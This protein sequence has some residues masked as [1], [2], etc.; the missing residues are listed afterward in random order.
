MSLDNLEKKIYQYKNSKD[1]KRIDEGE[2]PPSAFSVKEDWDEEDENEENAHEEKRSSPLRYFSWLLWITIPVLIIWGS[3][4]VFSKYFA[5]SKDILLEITAPEKVER[6]TPFDVKVTITNQTPDLL[7]QTNL[8]I[9]L[10]SGLV[11]LS[12]FEKNA[13]VNESLGDIGDGSFAQKT[14]KFLA[15]GDVN[16][17]QRITAS[18]SYAILKTRFEE[19][20]SQEILIDYPGLKIDIKKPDVLMNKSAFDIEIDYENTSA[21]DFSQLT[22]QASYPSEFEFISSDLPPTSL[23]NTWN[24]GELK[25]GS[26]GTFL[27]K[28]SL[29]IREQK[30]ISI[31]FIMSVNFFGKNYPLIDT[32]VSFA[33]APSP[34]HIETSI[35]N[36]NEYIARLG[37][38]LRYIIRYENQ[39][40][41]ALQ[42]AVVKAQLVGDLFDIETIDTNG[43]IDSIRKSITWNKSN[44][45]RLGIV[46]PG[47]SDQVGFSIKLKKQFPIERLS[48][49]NFTVRVDVEITSPSVPY[50]LNSKE[51]SANTSMKTQ[52]AGVLELDAQGYYRDAASGI[53][54][55][56]T[57]PPRVN[58]PT[59]FTIHWILKSYAT[60]MKNIEVRTNLASGAKPTGIIK[61]N[62][63]S[64]PLYNENTQ[65]L[66]W[67]IGKIPANK[68]VVG[69][70]IEAIFQVELTPSSN[71][72]GQYA[73]LMSESVARGVDEFTGL[74]MFSTDS[75]ITTALPDDKTLQETDKRVVQ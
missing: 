14:Y 54:N 28:G 56:G 53:A 17:A 32:V 23:N 57:V 55:K 20:S 52:V 37:D 10:P 64:V 15:V 7:R 2:I 51:T 45:E 9:V 61:S 41:I 5:V 75:A 25:S 12:S 31:P 58:T 29:N 69:D 8:S 44:V 26:K 36:S 35:N 22:I 33:S 34:L 24:L 50:Y 60:D 39:T 27:I 6:G 67:S 30:S 13:L 59:T 47:S 71:L 72:L 1:R 49:K 48:D 68:G 38:T 74:A 43:N 21:V 46:E 66:V 73:P 3:I 4:T 40:G 42:D 70:P 62:I 63:D 65:E 18:F 11:N 16:S 19:K